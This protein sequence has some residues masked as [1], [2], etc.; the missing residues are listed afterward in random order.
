MRITE[1]DGWMP[2]ITTLAVI[3][4]KECVTLLSLDEEGDWVALGDSEPADDDLDTLSVEELLALDA[5]LADAPDL[6]PGQCAVR[7]SRQT[8]WTIEEE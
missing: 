7:D 5:S 1:T 8:P 2:V 3:E 4:G 6:Q